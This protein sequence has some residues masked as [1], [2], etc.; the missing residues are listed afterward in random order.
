M[1]LP[2]RQCHR[3][4]RFFIA[5]TSQG[6]QIDCGAPEASRGQHWLTLNPSRLPNGITEQIRTSGG[7]FTT[8]R[9]AA[10]PREHNPEIPSYPGAR[11]LPSTHS[12]YT[13]SECRRPTAVREGGTARSTRSQRDN[14]LEITH[15]LAM[16]RHTPNLRIPQ[17]SPK[18]ANLSSLRPTTQSPLPKLP[19]TQRHAHQHP[20][21]TTLTTPHQTPNVKKRERECPLCPSCRVRYRRERR[22]CPRTASSM[23]G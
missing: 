5:S 11:T 18:S 17:D 15:L 21:H 20:H 4:R 3:R 9:E 22:A 14:H 6:R 7:R 23:L 2:S 12:K 8:N 13:E 19:T 16:P 10:G 1:A